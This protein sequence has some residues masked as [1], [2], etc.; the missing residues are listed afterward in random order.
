MYTG[1]QLRNLIYQAFAHSLL[2]MSTTFKFLDL[3]VGT[4]N[5]RSSLRDCRET[6]RVAVSQVPAVPQLMK[7]LG[8]AK[9]RQHAGRLHL[10]SAA[11]VVLGAGWLVARKPRCKLGV[12]HAGLRL[13]AGIAVVARHMDVHHLRRPRRVHRQNSGNTVLAGEAAS[14]PRAVTRHGRLVVGQRSAQLSARSH[15]ARSSHLLG[16]RTDDA[17]SYQ[18]AV[19]VCVCACARVCVCACVRVCVCACVR[20]CVCACV[21]VCVCACV[22]VCVCSCVRVCVC[23]VRASVCMTA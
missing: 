14:L 2:N 17:L 1:L 13:A 8:A 15:H 6:L 23:H 16:R 9:N 20:V 18:L 10:A 21:R 12:V 3:T 11:L 5:W 19:R 22:R 4:I 7:L